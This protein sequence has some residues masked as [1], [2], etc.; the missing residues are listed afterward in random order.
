ML[1]RMRLTGCVLPQGK[2]L[3]VPCI[4]VYEMYRLPNIKLT[5]MLI[6][7]RMHFEQI[8]FALKGTVPLG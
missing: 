2:A 7:L 8:A 1:E 3:N 5:L 4:I 6:N